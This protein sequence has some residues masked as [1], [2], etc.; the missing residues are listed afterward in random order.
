VRMGSLWKC[1]VVWTGLI[2]FSGIAWGSS[3][4]FTG[5]FPGDD[6]LQTLS[7]T[8][9]PASMVTIRSFG[10][11]GGTNSVGA[12]IPAGGLDSYFSLFDPTGLL[13]DSNDDDTTGTVATDPSTGNAFDALLRKSSLTAGTYLLVL[14]EVSNTPVGT[15]FADGFSGVGQ[16]N[17]TCP[18]LMGTSGPFCDLTPSQRTGNW[19]I[20]ISGV[21]AAS[22]TTRQTGAPEP[23]TIVLMGSCVAAVLF[24]RGRRS[25]NVLKR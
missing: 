19:A 4:S 24:F 13:I 15:T 23:G 11:G 17:F 22:D 1:A 9:A 7:F 18:A 16:G 14:T 20:D 25:A 3:F 8:V 12:T 21:T 6:H 2:L 5:T 10:Y